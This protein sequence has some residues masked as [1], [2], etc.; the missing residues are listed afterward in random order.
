MK[1]R[2]TLR[3]NVLLAGLYGGM[4]EVVWVAV[5][6]LLTGR[7]SAEVARQVTATVL[8]DAA[9][10]SAA[11][12]LGIGI[13]FV[14]AVLLAMVFVRVVWLPFTRRLNDVAATLVACAVLGAIW[15]MNFFLVLPAVNPAFV[16]LLPYAVTLTSKLLFGVAMAGALRDGAGQVSRALPFFPSTAH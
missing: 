5:Y 14:L 13:H 12:A 8:P 3:Q 10:G 7:S 9:T 4:A 1:V 6:C 15:A 11:V 16:A 2:R